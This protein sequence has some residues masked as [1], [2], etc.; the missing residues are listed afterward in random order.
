MGFGIRGIETLC[1][2]AR[3]QLEAASLNGRR[4]KHELI[5]MGVRWL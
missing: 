4:I 1:S 2:A 3:Y 5:K